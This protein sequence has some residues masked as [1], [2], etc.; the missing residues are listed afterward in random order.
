[1]PWSG[2][3]R[4]RWPLQAVRLAVLALSILGTPALAQAPPA[5]LYSARPGDTI[6]D[7]SRAY[8]AD[9]RRWPE[10]QA[11]NR[12]R[13]PER[14]PPGQIL[15]IPLAWL[16]P[17]HAEAVPVA[18]EAPAQVRQGGGAWG[19]LAQGTALT[20]GDAIATGP[21][22]SVTLRLADGSRVLI[23]GGTTVVMERLLRFEGTPLA[24]SRFRLERG[25]LEQAD[26]TVG[27][28]FEVASPPATTSVRGTAFR[29]ALSDDGGQASTEVLT[30][31]V[32]VTAE[33]RTV[34][35][36]AGFGTVAGLDTPP[37]AP[38]PLLPPPDTSPTPDLL[39]RLPPTL[40]VAAQA[41][42]VRYRFVIAPDSTF[43][44]LLAD[45]V[46]DGPTFRVP[47]LADGAYVWRVRAIDQLGLEGR[48][49]DRAFVLNAHPEPPAPLEPRRAGRVRDAAPRFAWAE[50][51]D[52]AGYKF[53]LASAAAPDRPLLE[54]TDL[55]RAEL[56]PDQP[57]PP[58][59]YVWQVATRSADGEIGPFSDPQPF[60]RLEPA[61]VPEPAV[62]NATDRMLVVQLPR[63]VEG[64][65]YRVQLARD[66]AFSELAFD[67]VIEG[68]ELEVRHLY[69]DR[70]YL[71]AQAIESDGYEGA[72]SAPQRI[73]V[74]PA[75]WWPFVA[76]PLA[77][78]LLAL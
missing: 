21:E 68:T 41:G 15:R 60:T 46:R 38:V 37:A 23:P 39:E 18:V 5:W 67:E 36:P 19:P 43:A 51:V 63:A 2:E 33:R 6:W 59:E 30:G 27:S 72:F 12:V 42:A 56:V 78:L 57:L 50:P 47:D 73:D 8:L 16:R 65:R 54:R 1:M 28:R 77:F 4:R 70:Y 14:I 31:S 20:E 64:A 13:V 55:P 61:P 48:H 62:A 75:R 10:L 66:A 24:D 11:L 34:S 35:V 71:R 22:G 58:G 7:L 17:V 76:I 44:T 32:G 29:Q 25:R 26:V 9:W 45:E 3:R 74:V 69:P 52:A 49:R 53:R 40:A